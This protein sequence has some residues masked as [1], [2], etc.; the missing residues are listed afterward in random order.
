MV[1]LLEYQ[2]KELLKKHGIPTPPGDVASTPEEARK[3]ATELGGRVVVKAQVPTSARMK[4]GLIKFADSPLAASVATLTLLGRKVDGF[5][6]EEVM[7][8]KRLEV[9]GEFYLGFIIDETIDRKCP[10]AI[11]SPEGGV[12]VEDALSKSPGRIVTAPIDYR[13]GFGDRQAS[14]L[15]ATAKLPHPLN[16]TLTEIFTRLY[17]IFKA[18]SARV[19]EINPLATTKE[20]GV[21]ALDCRVTVDDYA[22]RPELGVKVPREIPNPTELDVLAWGVE[23]GDFR[24]TFYFQQLAD[25]EETRRGGYVGFHG[26]GGGPSILAMDA[27]TRAG[28][29]P[30]N[31]SDTSGNPTAS[32]VYRCAKII[33]SQPG[34]DGY[35]LL[36][37][38]VASQDMR[39]TARGLVKAFREELRDRPGFPVVVLWGGNR[40]EEATEI[41]KEGVRELPLHLEVYGEEYIDQLEFVVERARILVE[42]GRGKGVVKASV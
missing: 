16:S 8:E 25:P 26:I 23:E 15:L 1:R 13:R 2:G 17:E 41:M 5:T 34:I 37:V 29:R 7:V 6:V 24:G 40:I 18:Y 19:V 9:E 31:Y 3:K 30:A 20:G 11:F 33:L 28:L 12:E 36:S 35:M 4:R 10:V 32:K 42:E 22:V 27:L 21:W 14:N 39:H 38:A